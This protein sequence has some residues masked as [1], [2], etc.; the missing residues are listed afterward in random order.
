MPPDNARLA[1]VGWRHGGESTFPNFDECVEEGRAY[2]CLW[3]VKISTG[4]PQIPP[5]RNIL[6]RLPLDRSDKVVFRLI[7]W[8]GVFYII[9]RR[10]ANRLP[11][12]TEHL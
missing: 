9:V 8:D 3:T 5:L 12:Q 4:I 1:T 7:R 11:D 2:P 6:L 10:V